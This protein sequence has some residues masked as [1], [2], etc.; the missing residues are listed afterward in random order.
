MRCS[1]KSI[2]GKVAFVLAINCIVVGSNLAAAPWLQTIAPPWACLF[3]IPAVL[4]VW[5]VCK[6]LECLPMFPLMATVCASVTLAVLRWETYFMA[7]LVSMAVYTRIVRDM[8][9]N[10]LN[11]LRVSAPME[12]ISILSQQSEPDGD[13]PPTPAMYRQRRKN[14]LETH[15]TTDSTEKG[16]VESEAMIGR[17]DH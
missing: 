11:S 16:Q 12:G 1:P 3:A 9:A 14:R 2:N 13:P 7:A 8:G 4:M 6:D 10:H 5:K 17:G 15:A